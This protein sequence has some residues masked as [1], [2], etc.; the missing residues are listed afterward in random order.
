MRQVVTFHLSS[1]SNKM[2]FTIFYM[3]ATLLQ[4]IRLGNL[5]NKLN[6]TLNSKNA[7]LVCDE[8]VVLESKRTR[9]FENLLFRT[10]ERIGCTVVP[11][12]KINL[13]QWLA[14]PKDSSYF[15][16]YFVKNAPKLESP[17]VYVLVQSM[18]ETYVKHSAD[19]VQVEN[20]G[21]LIAWR[22]SDTFDAIIKS[23]LNKLTRIVHSFSMNNLDINHEL[24]LLRIETVDVE[25]LPTRIKYDKR[26][27]KENALKYSYAPIYWT[28]FVDS[29]KEIYGKIRDTKNPKI[30][31]ESGKSEE[32]KVPVSEVKPIKKDGKRSEDKNTLEV[33]S[34]DYRRHK[35]GEH[36]REKSSEKHKGE[37]TKAETSSKSKEESKHRKTEDKHK[38]KDES[39]TDGDNIRKEAREEHKRKEKEAKIKRETAT[40]EE[41]VP[42]KSSKEG[43]EKQHKRE[44][45]KEPPKKSKSNVE[46]S[47]EAAKKSEK[48]LSK[49]SSSDKKLVKTAALCE[50]VDSSPKEKSH[51]PKDILGVSSSSYKTDC[52]TNKQ[53][54]IQSNG[55]MKSKNV[56]PPN[57]LIFADSLL[58]KENVK[59]VFINMLN[60]EKYVIYDLPT[61]P[62]QS[63][64]NDSTALV[65]VCGNVPPNLTSQLLQYL[66]DGG[67]LLCLCSDFLYCVLHTFTT[68]EVREHELVRFSY[69]QWTQ[70][71]MM[72]HI[73]CY[74]ASPTKKQFSK[75]SDHSNQSSGNGSSP[76]APRTPSA[77]EI[78]H[79]GKDYVIQVQIL[80]TEE[81]W[82]TPSLLLATVK[83]SRGRAIFSQVHLEI[84]PD[85]FEDDEN[86]FKALKESD[87]ARIEILKDILVH[88]LGID[89]TES[90]ELEYT[91]GYFLGR[92]D[93]KLKLLTECKDI[94]DMRLE[95]SKIVLKFCGKD[96]K[97]DQATSNFMPIFIHT[98]PSNFS[99]VTYFESL[100][101]E[102]IGRL[103]IYSD[104]ITGSQILLEKNLTHGIVVI[105]R[106]QTQGVGRSNNKWISSMGSALF[107]LQIIISLNSPL[108]K[109]LP[110]I[111]HLTMVAVVS[112]IKK[113]VGDSELDIGIKWPND[114]YADKSVKIGGLIVNSNV[115]GDTVGIVIGCGVNLDNANPTTCINDLIRKRNEAKGTNLRPISY[116]VYFASVFNEFE[117]LFLTIQ[118]GNMDDFYDLYYQYWL[119]NNSDVTVQVSKDETEKMHI[120][121]IDDFGFL[122]VRN[123]EGEIST[124][125]PDGNSFDMLQG[126]ISRK[127]F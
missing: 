126:L 19:I 12:Q 67:Q 44:D 26:F 10:D 6:G 69:G 82:Q 36:R 55:L 64:W 40:T 103:V 108:G 80:G 65:V 84:N 25:G 37:S 89:C 47:L 28:K 76:V 16:I 22:A 97:P 100:A 1:H 50:D 105:P 112:A 3:Y 43:K 58:A 42:T 85:Q 120:V 75:E 61:D 83:G 13:S 124:I 72:H 87:Q 127:M 2:F 104:V 33:G 114:L 113:A 106:Q 110:L 8:S 21:E 111:Q 73:F 125:H 74:Q 18:L 68:A 49:R 95:N 4:R 90:K 32:K 123:C 31:I 92:H 117:K 14:F 70:V 24:R 53:P 17:H 11:K 48:L 7:L 38:T 116:E 66:L 35:S 119:H 15:P 9:S 52:T 20:Y 62:K 99:T 122:K 54:R 109:A 88:Q 63:M 41:T 56:K 86:K 115:Q 57:I 121:G 29:I 30:T 94:T 102:E 96:E 77:V 71:K 98:C 39:K 60:K 51:K 27:A 107:S 81:T 34:G 45:K 5:K 23:D 79:N 91:P 59:S 101:T 46:K 93:L 118:E 78:Q